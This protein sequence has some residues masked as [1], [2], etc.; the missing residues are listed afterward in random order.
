VYIAFLLVETRHRRQLVSYLLSRIA[1]RR[2]KQYEATCELLSPS[3]QIMALLKG[4]ALFARW[5]FTG[6]WVA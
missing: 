3:D 2:G 5:R 1:G 4:M 6:R